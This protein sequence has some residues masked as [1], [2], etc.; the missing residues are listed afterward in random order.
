[1]STEGY[2]FLAVVFGVAAMFIF[3]SMRKNKQSRESTTP[4]E[5]GSTPSRCGHCHRPVAG[6]GYE[7]QLG[8]V[9]QGHDWAPPRGRYD[10]NLNVD[11]RSHSHGKAPSTSTKRELAPVERETRETETEETE[12]PMC[13]KC[14]RNRVRKN[15]RGEWYRYCQDCFVPRDDRG[16]DGDDDIRRKREEDRKREAELIAKTKGSSST[17]LPGGKRS[18]FDVIGK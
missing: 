9:C 11:E 1:M 18:I 16:G 5:N 15:W 10:I 14:G 17:T 4:R 3:Q 12:A 13:T 8:L 7:G 2:I 6:Y